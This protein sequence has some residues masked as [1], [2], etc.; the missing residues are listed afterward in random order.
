MRRKD[1][2][3]SSA[4]HWR[5]LDGRHI[6]DFCT[7]GRWGRLQY[8]HVRQRMPGRHRVTRLNETNS[9]EIKCVAFSRMIY[10]DAHWNMKRS[11]RLV[12]RSFSEQKL[13]SF[14]VSDAIPIENGKILDA[15]VS[16]TVAPMSGRSQSIAKQSQFGSKSRQR[17]CLRGVWARRQRDGN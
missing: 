9:Y 8:R 16:P 2:S 12:G 4:A 7:T 15:A 6:T 5:H 10:R 1:E 11:Y 3:P 17:G 14:P 13:V